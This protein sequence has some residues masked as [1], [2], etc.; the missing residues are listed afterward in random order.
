MKGIF[1][2]DSPLM[3]GVL[4]VFDSI[5]LSILWVLF[6]LPLITI[7]A[8]S[9]ALYTTVYKYLRLGEGYLWRTFWDAFRENLRR[10]T[11]IWLCVVAVSAVLTVDVLVFR[12]HRINGSLLGGGY[13]VVLILCCVAV[14]WTA[15][16]FAYAARFNGSVKDVLRF[17][18]LLM[19]L[20]PIRALQVFFPLLCSGM[21]LLVAPGMLSVIPAD[22]CWLNS[23]TLER[24]FMLHMSPED[25]EKTQAQQTR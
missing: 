13:W 23:M 21:L 10:S 16:L 4:K 11:V 24:V 18:L 14:T 25:W 9:T 3:S 1:N 15:Y 6:S 17:S 12:T 22:I 7:G 8:S 2:I 19:A 5:C 20:H